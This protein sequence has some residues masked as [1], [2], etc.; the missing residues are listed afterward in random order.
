[1]LLLLGFGV[2]VSGYSQRTT[3]ENPAFLN[4]VSLQSSTPLDRSQRVVFE[5]CLRQFENVIAGECKDN[6]CIFIREQKGEPRDKIIE[7]INSKGLEFIVG[8]NMLNVPPFVVLNPQNASKVPHQ[9]D[10]LSSLDKDALAQDTYQMTKLQ[11]QEYLSSKY[12]DYLAKLNPPT[13]D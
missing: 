6:T 3:G 8:N 10:F 4:I 12:H 11:Y 5:K 2:F 13:Q 9:D 7:F 1:M